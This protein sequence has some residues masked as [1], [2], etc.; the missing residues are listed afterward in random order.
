MSAVDTDADIL[1]LPLK[2]P[3]NLLIT[4]GNTHRHRRAKPHGFRLSLGI[5]I[6]PPHKFQVSKYGLKAD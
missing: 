5:S 2:S 3:R 1:P 4:R 6:P